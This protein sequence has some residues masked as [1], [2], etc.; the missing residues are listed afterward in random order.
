M[1]NHSYLDVEAAKMHHQALLQE[2]EHDR[3]VRQL[4]AAHP[5]L[6]DRARL[7]LG[8]RLVGWGTRLQGNIA[9]ASGL[10]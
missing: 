7:Y 2:V 10:D 5:S 1:L 4:Q 6:A 3:L 8:A 9:P